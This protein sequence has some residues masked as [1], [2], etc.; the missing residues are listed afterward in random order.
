MCPDRG[1]EAGSFLSQKKDRNVFPAEAEDGLQVG[2]CLETNLESGL[3]PGQ[4]ETPRG[5]WSE[6][7]KQGLQCF[8][9]IYLYLQNF[10]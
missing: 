6:T 4:G 8:I 1:G 9:C 2:M 5:F 7:L 3:T 10:L